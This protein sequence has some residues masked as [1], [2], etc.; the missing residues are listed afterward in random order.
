MLGQP[1]TDLGALLCRRLAG[2]LIGLD[3]EMRLRSFR[4]VLPDLVDRV[5]L[6]RHELGAA[7]RERFLRLLHPVARVQPGIVADARA[8]GRM[9]LEPL[10]RA[11]L[12]HRLVAPL[13]GADL[14]ADLKR[15][16][17]I[18]ED[19]RFLGKYYRRTGGALKAREPGEPLGVASD[20][21]AH[22]FV[23]ERNDE[24]VELLGFQL[25]AKCGEAV[26][27]TGHG[28]YSLLSQLVQRWPPLKTRSS[29]EHEEAGS[30]R[31][32]APAGQ[33]VRATGF[34]TRIASSNPRGSRTDQERLRS[35]SRRLAPRMPSRFVHHRKDNETAS[36]A[37][38]RI[39]PGWSV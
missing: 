5:L 38:K 16:A 7:C 36:S 24:A 12:R 34:Q 26:C 22:M 17:A 10:R 1:V 14:L 21:F 29:V 30:L 27:I 13:V 37:G 23:G 9:F 15:V 6:H 32:G 39:R 4:P 25:L 20:I 33:A 2:V 28:R 18:D 11:R 31:G 8:L 35:N 19:G 3:D